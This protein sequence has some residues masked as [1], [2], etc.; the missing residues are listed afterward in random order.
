MRI[1]AV[2]QIT[3]MLFGA[4]VV[5]SAAQA[6]TI[7]TLENPALAYY[8]QT[9]NRPC[10]IGESSCGTADW[11]LD[12]GI[13]PNTPNNGSYAVYSDRDNDV[14]GDQPYT[15]GDLRLLGKGEFL[16]IGIDVNTNGNPNESLVYFSVA[17]DGVVQFYYNGPIEMQTPNNGT[18]YSDVM[19][20]GINLTGYANGSTVQFFAS[21]SNVTDGK[22]QFF[23]IGGSEIPDECPT[24][25]CP[26]PPC[27]IDCPPDPCT[28]DCPVPSPEPA[29]LLLLSTGAA[30]AA[31]RR[32]RQVR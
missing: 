3:F 11:G 8:K 19:L 25:G 15:V 4:I 2:G 32:R 6:A 21:V 23:L 10:V 5:P 1:R 9:E 31:V 18:G 26:P 29:T 20:K 12:Y 16:N 14:A 22:E 24:T 13:I 30:V 27:T 7:L 17:I 28:T